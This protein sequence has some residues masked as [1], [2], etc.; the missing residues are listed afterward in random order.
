MHCATQFSGQVKFCHFLSIASGKEISC[1][2]LFY[3]YL[4]PVDW[5]VASYKG[6]DYVAHVFIDDAKGKA[7]D[8][9]FLVFFTFAF[10]K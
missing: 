1:A 5:V 3:D 9:S 2:F 8:A 7:S 10:F 6:N 4:Q